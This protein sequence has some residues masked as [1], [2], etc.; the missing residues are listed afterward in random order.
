MLCEKI[1]AVVT[2]LIQDYKNEHIFLCSKNRKAFTG[3][4]RI[5]PAPITL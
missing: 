5:P 1:D 4:L 2:N 3:R